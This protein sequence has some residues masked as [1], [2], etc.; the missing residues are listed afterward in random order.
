MVHP[1]SR[2]RPVRRVRIAA[3]CLVLGAAPA[4]A[5]HGMAAFVQRTGGAAPTPEAEPATMAAP[6][7]TPATTA[8]TP[9]AAPDAEPPVTSASV[10]PFPVEAPAIDP[11]QEAPGPWRLFDGV[12]AAS[13]VTA[14]GWLQLGWHGD[15]TDL[16]NSDPDRLNLHQAWLFVEKLADGTGEGLGWGYRLDALWGTDGGDTNSF[17]NPD[18]GWDAEDSFDTGDGYGFAIPQLYVELASGDLNVK[19]GHFYTLIGYEVVGAPGNFFYSHAITM[20]NSEPFTHSG[21]LASWAASEDT[22]F[23][24]GWTAGWDTGFDQ[25]E[26]GSNLLGGV[27]TSLSDDAT[28]A[29]MTTIGDFGARGR[30]GFMQSVV[31]DVALTEDL[32]Y[33]G[34]SDI[35]RVGS[36]GEDTFGLNQYLFYTVD[37]DLALGARFEWWKADAMTGYAPHGGDLSGGSMISYYEAT[38]GAN[39]KVNE[40]IMVRPE[41]RYDWSEGA[42]YNQGILGVDV[43]ATF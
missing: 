15:S 14:G 42:D 10:A 37:E 30:D 20:Y 5:Q 43:I 28:I 29:Y 19:V 8:G 9:A 38:F 22:T 39:Y 12:F 27:S 1:V 4:A 34:Q 7:V 21:V 2:N 24:G 3:G 36:T 33:V 16:F 35:L 17:G 23:Y 11:E 32:N 18:G 13:D 41:F 26:D 40:N 31:V 25:F 6:T